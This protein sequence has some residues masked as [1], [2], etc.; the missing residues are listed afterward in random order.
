MI[1]D[2]FAIVSLHWLLTVAI[3]PLIYAT[4][5]VGTG[6]IERSELAIIAI[7]SDE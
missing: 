2:I 5:L 3:A 1:Y 4:I 7:P 6:G